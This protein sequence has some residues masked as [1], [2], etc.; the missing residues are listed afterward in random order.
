MVSLMGMIFKITV[1]STTTD[2]EVSDDFGVMLNTNITKEELHDA[3]NDMTEI[4]L[5]A[6]ELL[7]QKYPQPASISMH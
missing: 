3:L 2:I 7:K 6:V 4:W 5:D 1:G